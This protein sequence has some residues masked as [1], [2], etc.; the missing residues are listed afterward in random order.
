MTN[1]HANTA[2]GTRTAM[3]GAGHIASVTLLLAAGARQRD[4][5]MASERAM[6]RWHPGVN[7]LE[8]A[9]LQRGR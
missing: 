6:L 2:P 4:K 9:A 5:M 3:A 1:A 8:D 7:A